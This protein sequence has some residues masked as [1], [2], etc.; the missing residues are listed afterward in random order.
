MNIIVH[1]VDE[2]LIE[3]KPGAGQEFLVAGAQVV[4]EGLER[5]SE[6]QEVRIV[7]INPDFLTNLP[8]AF[9]HL[10]IDPKLRK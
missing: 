5:L 7:S 2:Y 4:T 10:T 3:P 8:Q 6:G 9:G 1:G